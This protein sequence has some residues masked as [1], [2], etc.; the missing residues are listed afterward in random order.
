MQVVEL[1]F[2]SNNVIHLSSK[3]QLEILDLCN[4]YIWDAV[5]LLSSRAS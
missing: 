1:L 5:T 2:I 3:S 4:V